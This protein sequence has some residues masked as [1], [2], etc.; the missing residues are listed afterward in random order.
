[1]SARSTTDTWGAVTRNL[2]WI[3]AI[4]VLG[5]L[6]HGWWMAH[7]AAREVRLWHYGTHGLIAVYFGLLLA[8]RVVWRLSEPTPHQPTG[9]A[10][11]Q[12][13]AAHGTHL[14]L[15]ALMIG[16]LVSG[17]LM[18]SSFPARFDPVRG[19][20]FDYT[21]FGL[22]KLPAASAT[23]SRDVAKYWEG[24]HE[25]LSHAMQLLVVAHIAA[26]LWHQFVKRDTVV[27]RMTHGRG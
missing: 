17:Y 11:W 24:V 9:T 14:V 22:F 27:A 25:L 20:P 6:G 8:L 26:A 13:V 18:W 3:S 21:L 15:Y 19:V 2:H 1:M 23:A 7:L 12:K 10:G 16:M 5:L 4:V